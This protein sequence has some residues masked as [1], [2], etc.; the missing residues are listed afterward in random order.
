MSTKELLKD[1]LVFLKKPHVTPLVLKVKE[2]F[3]QTLRL[4]CFLFIFIIF[5]GII[6]DSLIDVPMHDRFQEV[7]D[8]IG[9]WGFVG[10]AVVLGP[11]LEEV[12]FRLAMRFQLRYI[13]IGTI[14]LTLYIVQATSPLIEKS[15][16]D[17]LFYLY[18]FAAIGLG[19]FI[20][21]CLKYKTRVASGWIIYF[22]F[23]FY[24]LSFAFAMIHI[25]N[26]EA[27]PLRVIVLAPIITLPQFILGLGMGY[28]R[29]RFGFWYGYLFHVLN[30]GFALSVYLLLGQ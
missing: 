18:S 4:W 27:F 13:I 26:F 12:T 17:G 10:F 2:R 11:F 20:V 14:A 19:T 8:Q 23:V 9:L 25:F 15:T 1:F 3:I 30:N 7:M 21:L 24:A 29:M 22:P 5:G 16:S 6:I 28:L